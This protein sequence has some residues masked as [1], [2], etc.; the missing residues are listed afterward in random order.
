MNLLEQRQRFLPEPGALH[1][2][3][4]SDLLE[5]EL[6]SPDLSIYEPKS[7]QP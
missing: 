4:Q 7:D 3:R 5:L 1:L 6:P 2:T